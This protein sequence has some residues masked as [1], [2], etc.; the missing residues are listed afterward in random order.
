MRFDA[1]FLREQI[2]R[3][4]GGY[5]VHVQAFDQVCRDRRRAWLE[6]ERLE[7][8][9]QNLIERNSLLRTRPDLP[10][11]RLDAY[12]ATMSRLAQARR[13]ADALQGQIDDHVKARVQ[14]EQRIDALEY[15]RS[16][17]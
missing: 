16:K 8:E 10:I 12:D 14:L 1:S 6:V 13:H 3:N 17:L 9:K 4:W 7:D 11:E 5:G 15:D 2:V